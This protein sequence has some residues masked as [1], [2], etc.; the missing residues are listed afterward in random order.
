MIAL[1][2]VGLHDR[3]RGSK[4]FKGRHLTGYEEQL[5]ISTV[6]TGSFE[7]KL[8]DDGTSLEYEPP[9][10]ARRGRPAGTRP[11]REAGGQRWHLVLPLLGTRQRPGRDACMPG[12]EV[13]HGR[14]RDRGSRRGRPEHTAARDGRAGDRARRPERDPRG[15]AGRS[16]YANVHTTK[17]PG[18]EIRAQIKGGVPRPRQQPGKNGDDD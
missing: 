18:G 9:F 13:R 8:S 12:T 15:D 16:T 17:W 6:A 11:L 10:G 4:E 14:G 1:L 5:D 2:G 7:A 3:G